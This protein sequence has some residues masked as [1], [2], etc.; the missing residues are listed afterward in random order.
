MTNDFYDLLGVDEDASKEEIRDAFREMVQEYHPDRNDDPRA[1]AQ[2]TAIKKAYDTLKNSSERQSYD[3]LGHSTYVAKRMDG[4]PDPS[5]WPSEDEDDDTGTSGSSST[6]SATGSSAS[7]RSSTTSG[8]SGTTSGSSRTTGSSSGTGGSS[9][10]SHGPGSSGSGRTSARS[11][12]GSTSRSSSSSSTSG[13]SSSTSGSSRSGSGSSRS[14]SSSSRST[15]SGSSN[16][17]SA[18]TAS[19]SGSNAG[20]A[21]GSASG[22]TVGDGGTAQA[23]AAEAAANAA[24]N[25][26]SGGGSAATGSESDAGSIADNAVVQWFQRALFGWPSIFLST[27]LYLSG[28][29]YYGYS[30]RSGLAALAESLRAAGADTAALRAALEGERYGIAPATEYVST[31]PPSDPGSAASWLFAA[32]IALLPVLFFLVI[33]TTRKYPGWKPTYL[34]VVGVAAPAIGVGATVA[35]GGIP[36]AAELLA[37]GV[38]PVLAIA[39]LIGRGFVWPRLKS[40]AN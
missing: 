27:A 32:G 25:A 22:S 19:N 8:S 20:S 31:T 29:A 33:R 34:Y 30:N 4:M 37:Y 10:S 11:S 38:L 21:S 3:R 17:T 40:I 28:V 1:T 5:S 24:G 36:L 35:Q 23:G 15:T 2:F 16:S 39:T 6:S 12:T 9:T 26:A 7:G 14:S 13:S 18:G